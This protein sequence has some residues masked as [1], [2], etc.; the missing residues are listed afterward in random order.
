M[1]LGNASDPKTYK[2]HP[3]STGPYMIKS[4]NPS[5]ELVL[6]KNPFWD[7]KTAAGTKA[8]ASHIA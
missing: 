2:N 4:Y 3:L 1:P 5:K 8:R 6:V 7:P